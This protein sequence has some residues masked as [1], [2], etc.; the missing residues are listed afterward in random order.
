[1]DYKCEIW[2]RLGRRSGKGF[3]MKTVYRGYLIEQ[4]I[5]DSAW[6]VTKDGWYI[7]TTN[8]LD[9]AKREIDRLFL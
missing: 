3:V 6:R 2:G 4:S 1:M 7:I 9:A 8:T 5:F